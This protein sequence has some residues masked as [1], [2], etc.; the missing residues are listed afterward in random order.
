M[1]PRTPPRSLPT[2][3]RWERCAYFREVLATFCCP[4]QI[5]ASWSPGAIIKEHRDYDLGY[6]AGEVPVS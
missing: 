1:R 3:R 5:G 4:A 2:R 6:E